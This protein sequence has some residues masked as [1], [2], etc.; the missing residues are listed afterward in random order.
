MKP[1]TERED[2]S[3]EQFE[4][5]LKQQNNK[6]TTTWNVLL[7]FN[8]YLPFLG[9][10]VNNTFTELKQT[11]TSNVLCIPLTNNNQVCFETLEIQSNVI[12]SLND[13]HVVLINPHKYGYLNDRHEMN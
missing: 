11:N 2:L 5:N 3:K 8:P 9:E 7:C 6:R 10:E 12:M 1:N 4:H 13:T